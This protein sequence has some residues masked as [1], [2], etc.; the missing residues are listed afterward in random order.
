MSIY[1]VGK[2]AW[3]NIGDFLKLRNTCGVED[4]VSFT[5][6][7]YEHLGGV[8]VIFLYVM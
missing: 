8:G 2:T 1:G 6:N 4:M 3:E 7:C 5:T